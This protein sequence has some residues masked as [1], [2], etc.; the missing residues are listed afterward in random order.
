MQATVNFT[1]NNAERGGAHVDVNHRLAQ[2]FKLIGLRPATLLPAI[3]I[4]LLVLMARGTS[5]AQTM[6]QPTKAATQSDAQKA[7][8][9]MK[10]L[11]G[12]WQGTIMGISIN[13]TIR[14]ASSGTAILHEGNTDGG[15]PPN[16]E[17]TMFYREGDRLLATHYCD[18]GNRARF[19]GKMSPDGNT[20]EFNFLDVAGSTK[21]GLV[22]RMVFT[23]IDA[24]RHVI[25]F[26]FIMPNGK[27]VELRGEFQ[28]TK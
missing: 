13:I 14:A 8:E 25:E 28:R 24:N 21:G 4:C 20:I 19:E 7:F 26:T 6:S 3:L 17:I 22:K 10:T 2:L 11:A 15:G 18:G 5:V 16:H 1:Q 23:M 27:P 12:S 9:K